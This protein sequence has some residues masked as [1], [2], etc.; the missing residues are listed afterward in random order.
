[1]IHAAT[2]N[3]RNA[4]TTSMI[5]RPMLPRYANSR[6]LRTSA[7][8][9]LPGADAVQHFRKGPERRARPAPHAAAAAQYGRG[10]IA[11]DPA[12]IQRLV[13]LDQA[14]PQF[15]E[16]EHLLPGPGKEGEILRA[17]PGRHGNHPVAVDEPRIVTARFQ[18]GGGSLGAAPDRRQLLSQLAGA[19]SGRFGRLRWFRWFR[20][21]DCPGG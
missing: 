9:R 7:P 14:E 19:R 6:S 16:A 4:P 3:T 5:I 11:A 13:Q 21:R 15:G 12:G 8:V 2:T 20:R 10:C 1:M 18:P 17:E